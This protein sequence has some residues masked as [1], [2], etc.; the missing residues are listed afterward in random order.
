MKKLRLTRVIPL[1]AAVILILIAYLIFASRRQTLSY[2][3]YFAEEQVPYKEL[4]DVLASSIK[5]RIIFVSI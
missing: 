4:I 1:I 2:F 5:T 3:E